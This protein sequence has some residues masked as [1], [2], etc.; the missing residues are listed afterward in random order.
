[1]CISNQTNYGDISNQGLQS[2]VP[3]G[4]GQIPLTL[5]VGQLTTQS[6]VQMAK[7]QSM[8]IPGITSVPVI[9]SN[10][11]GAANLVGVTPVGPT[12]VPGA[13]AVIAPNYAK[14]FAVVGGALQ[15]WSALG[16]ANTAG[17]KIE[18]LEKAQEADNIKFRN[19]QA[20]NDLESRDTIDSITK[21]AASARSQYRV[22]KD[23]ITG[24][25]TA[26]LLLQ[27]M[28]KNELDMKERSIDIDTQK[29]IAMR[30]TLQQQYAQ[31]VA[32]AKEIADSVPTMA[33]LM[34][35]IATTAIAAYSTFGVGLFATG[36]GQA[37]I[38]RR[39]RYKASEALIGSNQ[40]AQQSLTALQQTQKEED[41]RLR[42]EHDLRLALAGLKRN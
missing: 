31:R 29:R 7:M 15:I 38:Q 27:D 25:S 1:M 4:T 30:D 12:T 21:Q 22:A 13:D 8:G 41:E 9:P 11:P 18:S 17:D 40:M 19:R 23:V 5:P 32:Q 39:E 35:G 6:T 10:V 2:Y 14:A 16:Q 24:G 34:I 36:M 3:Q 37:L 26:R 20:L 28:R 33:E 42:R